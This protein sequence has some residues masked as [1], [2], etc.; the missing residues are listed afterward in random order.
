[1]VFSCIK[2]IFI[3]PQLLLIL[4]I[5]FA[6]YPQYGVDCRPL[7]INHEQS[8][9]YELHLQALPRGPAPG[10]GGGGQGEGEP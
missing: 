2:I 5:I 6:N 4:L 9:A 7:L 8:R 10:S 1:M 3:V